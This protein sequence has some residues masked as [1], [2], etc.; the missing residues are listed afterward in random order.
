MKYEIR[1]LDAAENE[2]TKSL[3]QRVFK[4]DS[5]EFVEYY[6][7]YKARENRIYAAEGEDGEVLSMLH[8]NPYL[9]CLGT[10]EVFGEYI[11]AVATDEKCRRQGMM[12]RL[13]KTA[14]EDMWRIGEPF[15]FLMPADEKLYRPFGFAFIYRQNQG[16]IYVKDF[17]GQ[18]HLEC[19]RA[20]KKD[21][22]SL[23]EFANAYL[24]RN[25]RTFAFHMEEYF[26]TLLEEQKCQ[27]GDVVLICSQGRIRGYFFTAFEEGAE[28]RE[29]V[30]EEDCEA[31]SLPSLAHYLKGHGRVSLH[32]FSEDLMEV[33]ESKPMIMG[34]VV[35]PEQF[36]L[37][38][39]CDKQ[40]EFVFR[41]TDEL[42]P[43][44]TGIYRFHGDKEGGKLEK[45]KS[46]E[47]EFTLS[48]GEFTA[49]SFGECPVGI[50]KKAAEVWKNICTCGPVFINEVV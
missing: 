33:Q 40:V 16:R 23:A 41:L 32:G 44:N 42:L 14:L 37:C 36:A 20:G 18:P 24:K 45:C 46:E 8:L 30:A 5:T 12:R 34:R 48:I 35:N 2:K 38:L 22:P 4:E 21:I 43:Q 9:M 26:E 19:R 17:L 11:V 13:M 10:R 31:F 28:V 6:Y 25:Y 29:L 47:P 3:Y 39:A 1:L 15:A 49:L 50:S 7:R 27:G